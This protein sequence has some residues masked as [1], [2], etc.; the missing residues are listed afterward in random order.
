MANLQKVNLPKS[1]PLHKMTKILWLM[2]LGSWPFGLVDFL[3]VGHFSLYLKMILI[4][5]N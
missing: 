4:K 1:Q 3:E 2:F 5:L